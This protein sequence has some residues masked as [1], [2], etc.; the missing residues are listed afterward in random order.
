MD[1]IFFSS[2][3]KLLVL[4]LYRKTLKEITKFKKLDHFISD[5]YEIFVRNEFK[6]NCK[7]SK[8]ELISNHIK[9]GKKFLNKF[10]SINV[11][12]L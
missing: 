4:T 6:K 11:L 10:E 12:C 3:R 9:K 7:E 8:I 2:S 5:Y 1:A